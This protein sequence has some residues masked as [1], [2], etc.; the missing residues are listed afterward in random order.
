MKSSQLIK[1]IN[2][3]GL[4]ND[5]LTRRYPIAASTLNNYSRNAKPVKRS[6]DSIKLVELVHYA[7]SEI[8]SHPGVNPKEELDR[9]QLSKNMTMATFLT[10]F[11]KDDIDHLKVTVKMAI[12]NL[13]RDKEPKRAL[14]TYLEK[15]RHLNDDTLEV[16]TSESPELV[17]GIVIDENIKPIARAHALYALGFGAREEYF[18]FIKGFASHPSP[19][20][21]ESTFMALAQYYDREENRHLELKAY[22]QLGLRIEKGSGVKQKLSELLEGMD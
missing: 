9:L 16:A 20:M 3:F 5:E 18:S 4:S 2:Q 1:E 17:Q 6:S 12:E 8:A 10:Q 19:F 15:Y 11:I 13:F 14:E 21:R 7:L 22:F